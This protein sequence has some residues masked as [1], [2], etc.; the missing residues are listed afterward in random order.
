MGREMDV[1]SH[2]VIYANLERRAMKTR[3]GLCINL[4]SSLP[5]N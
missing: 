1:D 2:E 3:L 4:A 5:F